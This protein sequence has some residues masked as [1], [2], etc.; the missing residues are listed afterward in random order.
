[1]WAF[2]RRYPRAVAEPIIADRY[3]SKAGAAAVRS[4]PATRFRERILAYGGPILV[5]NGDLD[6][7]FRLGARSFLR[8]VPKVTRRTLRWTSH[9][10]PIDR[11]AAFA[12]AVARFADRLSS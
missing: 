2:R 4:L 8:G 7:V 12:D 3:W 11:P 6:V 10:S 1:S 5:I 9:L